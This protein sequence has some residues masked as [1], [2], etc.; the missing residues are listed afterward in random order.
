MPGPGHL[1]I[2]ARSQPDRSQITARSQPDPSCAHC[3]A[4]GED[5]RCTSAGASPH[6]TPYQLL[7]SPFLAHP[8]PP[9]LNSTFLTSPHPTSTPHP[10]LPRPPHLTS[11]GVCAQ[12]S[13]AE[14]IGDFEYFSR[15]HPEEGEQPS[16]MRRARGSGPGGKEEVLLDARRLKEDAALIQALTGQP[17]GGC[18]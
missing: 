2:T 15:P 12:D 11:L 1:E 18:W 7:N 3:S 10:T 13:L 4:M 8:T 17:V 5:R 14:A 6:L 9:H 16:Y